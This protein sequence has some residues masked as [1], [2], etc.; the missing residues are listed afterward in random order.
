MTTRG[1]AKRP[2]TAGRIVVGA[3]ACNACSGTPRCAVVTSAA[4]ACWLTTLM[5]MTVKCKDCPDAGFAVRGHRSPAQG[6]SLPCRYVR[7]PEVTLGLAATFDHRTYRSAPVPEC[8]DSPP[9][10]DE[11]FP[12]SGPLTTWIL[13]C[14][15]TACRRLSCVDASENARPFLNRSSSLSLLLWFCAN[16]TITTL[17]LC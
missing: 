9:A 4:F 10:A 17:P 15:R 3:R 12:R 8:T 16:T 1:A 2:A 5:S 7:S 11:V 13:R 6:R 14:R